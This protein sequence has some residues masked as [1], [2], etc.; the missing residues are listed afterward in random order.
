MDEHWRIEQKHKDCCRKCDGNRDCRA[1]TVRK[2]W[3]SGGWTLPEAQEQVSYPRKRRCCQEQYTPQHSFVYNAS[4][5][6][7]SMEERRF[8]SGDAVIEEGGPGDF[9]YVTGSGELEVRV[10]PPMIIYFVAP[11]V[12]P[13]GFRR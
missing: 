7:D 6:V 8:Q 3:H 1:Y 12:S 11:D 9:F 5:V 4:Q 10:P 2:P 13:R